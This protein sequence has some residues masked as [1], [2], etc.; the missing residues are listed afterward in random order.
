MYN[1]LYLIDDNCIYLV[2]LLDL[3]MRVDDIGTILLII[4]SNNKN[5]SF[6][7]ER[8][9]VET[10]QSNSYHC[11]KRIYY[12]IKYKYIDHLDIYIIK[13]WKRNEVA[14]QQH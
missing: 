6:I 3:I 8:Q 10:H 12:C 5:G 11:F 9:K 2:S 14:P 7:S 13:A 4:I 1:N